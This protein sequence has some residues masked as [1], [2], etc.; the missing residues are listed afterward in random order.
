MAYKY[1]HSFKSFLVGTLYIP[2]S[3]T[4]VKHPGPKH[5]TRILH[6]CL[7]IIRE[8]ACEKKHFHIRKI[9]AQ[10]TQN[11]WWGKI[12]LIKCLLL[13][14]QI[15]WAFEKPITRKGYARE[16]SKAR[17]VRWMEPNALNCYQKLLIYLL[18]N[19]SKRIFSLN[20]FSN[21]RARA[22]KKM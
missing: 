19:V 8:K 2:Q 6:F 17:F 15:S 1:W 18:S 11:F 21:L 16:I 3:E 9:S 12:L 22:R 14:T 20:I 7:S 13:C 4:I 10:E 5:F